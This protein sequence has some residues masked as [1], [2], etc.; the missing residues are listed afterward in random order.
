MAGQMPFDS[1][2]LQ[3]EFHY[4]YSATLHNSFVIVGIL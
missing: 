3:D 1:A 2:W 4:T